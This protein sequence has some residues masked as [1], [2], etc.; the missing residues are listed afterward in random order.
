MR[1]SP[2]RRIAGAVLGVLSL[3]QLG[4]IGIATPASAKPG[5]DLA[6]GDTI[7]ADT[8]LHADLVDCPN[9]GIVIGADN[10]KLDLNGHTIDGDVALLDPCPTDEPCDIGVDNTGGHRGVVVAG[11]AIKE[12]G[13]GVLIGGADD[14]RLTWLRITDSIFSGIVAFDSTGLRVEHSVIARNGLET[15]QAGITAFG[16]SDGTIARSRI[17][18]N[19]DIGL[20]AEGIDAH[21][22][23]GNT[24]SGNT[25]AGMLFDGSRNVVSSNRVSH[26]QD[27]IIFT[28]DDNV[29]SRNHITGP[30]DCT[31]CGSGISFEGGARNVLAR[32]VVLRGGLGIHVAAFTGFAADTTIR[33]NLVVAAAEDNIAI[34]LEGLGV[35]RTLVRGNIVAFA[36][37]DGI[38]ARNPSTT[39]S[40]NVAIRNRDLGIEAVPGVTDGGRN[41]AVANGNA[42][43]CTN[44]SC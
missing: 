35:E 41:R 42:Q 16:V 18:D 43:Q 37:D 6:C 22:I 44:V 17:A 19:G 11:G 38:D 3:A 14:I 28:G 32:N 7:T 33:D 24:F 20:F 4:V 23:V 25:E 21:H 36:G 2:G 13:L 10:I 39:L 9:N 1:P 26:G 29:V 15:D 30:A 27:G 31:T 8:T 34:D 5:N 12:F 40:G